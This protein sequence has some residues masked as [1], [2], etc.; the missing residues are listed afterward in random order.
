MAKKDRKSPRGVDTRIVQAGRGKALT[1]PYVNPPVHHAST[2][3]FETYAELREGVANMFDG[4]FYGRFGTPTQWSLAEAMAELEGGAGARLYPSGLAAITSS[5]LALLKAGDH[6]L[7]VDTVYEPTR[8]FCQHMLGRLAIETTFYDPLLGSGIEELFRDNTRVVFA[9]SPGSLTMEVQDLPAIAAVAHARG[10]CVIADNTWATPLYFNALEHGADISIHAATKYIV[11][12][13]DAML[14]VATANERCWNRLKMTTRALGQIAG[15]DDAYLGQRGL[16][17]LAPRLRTHQESGL[18]VARWLAGHPLVH[19]V[20]HPAL[21]DAPGHDIWRRD[22]SGASGLFSIVL[23]GG[24]LENIGVM[25]DP[26]E[27][28]AMGFSWGGYESLIL[29]ADP[30]QTRTAVPWVAPGPLLR[31]QIGL[32]DTADLIADLDAGLARFQEILN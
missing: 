11:G 27:H 9:E 3:L 12:H 22:F 8:R 4:L 5:L 18:I 6:L 26:M 7:M 10:A 2:I 13:S 30:A 21:E 24:K 20:L 29:P 14:G 28:F 16:R 32:E 31:L 25:V 15:P 23:T 1:G 19:Q 17:T